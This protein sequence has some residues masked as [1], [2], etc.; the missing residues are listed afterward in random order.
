MGHDEKLPF[1]IEKSG[2]KGSA[3]SGNHKKSEAGP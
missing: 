2:G 3:Q 1:D